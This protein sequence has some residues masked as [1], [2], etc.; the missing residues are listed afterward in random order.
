MRVAFITKDR[1]PII[2]VREI[3]E[4]EGIEVETHT[5]A[6]S[7]SH[8]FHSSAPDLAILNTRCPGLSAVEFIDRSRSAKKPFPTMVMAASPDEIDEIMLLRMG[9]M[10]YVMQDLSP[11]VMRERIMRAARDGRVMMAAN[12]PGEKDLYTD[13]V[14]YGDIVIDIDRN[15]VTWKGVEKEFTIRET[16]LLAALAK[17]P[18]FIWSRSKI[19]DFIGIEVALDERSIDSFIKR[20]RK[21]FKETDKSFDAITT[22]YGAGYC[23]KR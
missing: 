16:A 19:M 17:N 14:Q 12:A 6:S 22:I 2:G 1:T 7:A 5:D 8:A 3:L 15:V 23:F 10:D 4:G 20:I 18:G 21:N 9:A 13:V 11:R